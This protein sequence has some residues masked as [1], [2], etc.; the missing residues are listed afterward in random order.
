VA[1]IRSTHPGQWTSGDF[2][3]CSP[4]ARLLA[5]AVR[6]VADDHGVFRWKPTSLKAECLLADNCDIGALLGELVLNNQVVRYS[7]DGKEYGIIKDF[8]QW[9]R[10]KSRN[11][12]TQFRT[13]SPPVPYWYRTSSPPVPN[14]RTMKHPRAR[15][16]TTPNP[17]QYGKSSAEEGGRRKEERRTCTGR[18]ARGRSEAG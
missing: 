1:R 18:N 9:Q 16:G 5:L 10:P 7:V 13:G 11:T 3:E 6:N 12:S 2:L 8:T 4:L 17:H 15:T 14:S